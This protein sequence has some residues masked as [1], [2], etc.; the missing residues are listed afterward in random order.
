MYLCMYA[1]LESAMSAGVKEVAVFGAASQSFSK[2]NINCSVEESIVRFK[3]VIDAALA[4][5]IRVRGYVSCVLGCPYEGAINPANVHFVTKKLLD[6]GCYEV[7][8]GDTIGVGSAG[9]TRKLLDNLIHNN[10]PVDKLAVHFH[11]TYGQV[12]QL[13]VFSYFSLSVALPIPSA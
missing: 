6:M 8:L 3:D 5:N 9:T 13:E 4:N 1:G 12:I 11:D 10:L 7:S 2:K